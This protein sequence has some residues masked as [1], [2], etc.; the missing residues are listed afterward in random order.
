MRVKALIHLGRL[1]RNAGRIVDLIRRIRPGAVLC[2]VVKADAYGHGAVP[3][4][5]AAAAGGAHSLAVSSVAEGLE[6]REA[7]VTLPILVLSPPDTADLGAACRAG[8]SLCVGDPGI[9]REAARAADSSGKRL[10]LHL[11]IDTG[12][13]RSGCRPEDAVRAARL[14]KAGPFLELAGTST[15]FS[16]AESDSGED[17]AWT[18]IQL[19][20]FKEAVEAIRRDGIN[21][22]I[23]HAANSGALL[24]HPAACFDM[25]RCGI[26]LY[27]YQPKLDLSRTIAL[28]P[29]MEILSTVL[30]V[31][32]AGK[33]ETVS[34][35]RSWTV[36]HDT[37]LAAVP[38]GYGDGMPLNLDGVYHIAVKDKLYPIVGS[39]YMDSFMI[40]AGA[41]TGIARGDPVTI[42]GAASGKQAL[43]F[44][45]PADG[46]PQK[47]DRVLYE[48]TCC[49]TKRIP[50]VYV[51]D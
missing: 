16:C 44:P 42:F 34:Y 1:R 51:E 38:F 33:G 24:F 13:G 37:N 7:G 10:S 36:T 47:L 32:S 22:G 23:L 29:V 48:I 2:A 40:D 46:T 28:E 11:D 15:H 4:A 20:Q 14:I 8:L 50:K 39:I 25:V 26:M 3:A 43:V 9:I 31:K 41:N 17:I 45:A 12:M 27:G 35:G 49:L 6:L 19:A 21:P 18:N 5:V 30:Y